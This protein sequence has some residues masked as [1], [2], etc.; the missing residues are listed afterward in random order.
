MN[1][2][3]ENKNYKVVLDVVEEAGVADPLNWAIVN[4]NYN[5]VECRLAILPSAVF[6]ADNMD[7]AYEEAFEMQPQ[8]ELA[9]V[10]T[11]Q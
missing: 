9:D 2:V 7:K 4:K 6:T 10:T 3:Y 5:V 8:L 11:L 1:S